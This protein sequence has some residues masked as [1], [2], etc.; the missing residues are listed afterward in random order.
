M[1]DQP[2]LS[3]LE[4]GK[5][6]LLLVQHYRTRADLPSPDEGSTPHPTGLDLHSLSPIFV[7]APFTTGSASLFEYRFP[8][9][10][11]V[12]PSLSRPSA[13]LSIASLHSLPPS[14]HFKQHPFARSGVNIALR[15][16]ARRFSGANGPPPIC[17]PP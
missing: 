6:P 8:A 13:L 15:Q 4:R 9:T 17:V 11:A 3:T 12:R 10:L 16:P 2:R 14:T 7:G 1:N 5:S